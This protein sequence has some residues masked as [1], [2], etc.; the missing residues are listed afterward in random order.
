MHLFA[1]GPET[2]AL[3]LLDIDFHLAFDAL[4]ARVD[5]F[6]QF[7]CKVGFCAVAHCSRSFLQGG[8]LVKWQLEI[9]DQPFLSF[10]FFAFWE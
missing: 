4:G 10:E 1:R 3:V 6:A 2:E 7:S 8:L 5:H 9:G